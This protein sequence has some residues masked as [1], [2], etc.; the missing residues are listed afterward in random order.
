MDSQRSPKVVFLKGEQLLTLWSKTNEEWNNFIRD[1]RVQEITFSHEHFFIPYLDNL[2]NDKPIIY[3]IDIE[4]EGKYLSNMRIHIEPVDTRI[5]GIILSNSSIEK[6]KIIIRGNHISFIR[7]LFPIIRNTNIS[8]SVNSMDRCKVHL[9]HKKIENSYISIS[10]KIICNSTID[11][12]NSIVES[13]DLSIS[14]ESSNNLRIDS[15]GITHINS[16]MRIERGTHSKLELYLNDKPDV[17]GIKKN[18]LEGKNLNFEA[19]HINLYESKLEISLPAISSLA[20]EE[21]CLYNTDIQIEKSRIEKNLN[22][23]NI[24][25]IN[26]NIS[27]HQTHVDGIAYLNNIENTN[28]SSKISFE[29]TEFNSVF[30][31]SYKGKE[32]SPPDLTSTTFAGKVEI[33]NIN[34]YLKRS[35]LPIR[36][37]VRPTDIVAFRRLK[38]LAEE[39]KDHNSALQFHADE[40]RAK[41]W[42]ELGFWASLLDMAFSGFSNYGQ[43]VA[44]PAAWLFVTWI[45]LFCAYTLPTDEKTW[46]IR[47]I[48]TK[49]GNA[50]EFIL[51]NSLP[52]VSN[53][54]YIRQESMAELFGKAPPDWLNMLTIGQGVVSFALL[55]LIGLGLRNRF[56]I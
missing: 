50:I 20:L 14:I 40:M 31:L 51:T 27:I 7:F 18:D 32:A 28:N 52:F 37:S 8:F 24:S 54:K 56:R 43:S 34:P 33:K 36:K 44:R 2:S 17:L 48:A 55:F 13:S 1:N 11:L 16:N 38:E 6:S 15:T 47:N 19:K 39:N 46:W 41:R 23:E 10:S 9:H 25:L 30:F 42:H 5:S 21:V 35:P 53:A 45:G 4:F 49:G 29:S 26:S 22:I 12:T 3:P